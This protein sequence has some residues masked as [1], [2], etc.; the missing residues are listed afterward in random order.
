MKYSALKRPNIRA[1]ICIVF[2][3]GNLN[4]SRPAFASPPGK[5]LIQVA[6]VKDFVTGSSGPATDEISSACRDSLLSPVGDLSKGR[7]LS[8]KKTLRWMRRFAYD[9]GSKIKDLSWN[10]SKSQPAGSLLDRTVHS[11]SRL[12]HAAQVESEQAP[13]DPKIE[14]GIPS[15]KSSS[16]ETRSAQLAQKVFDAHPL[17]TSLSDEQFLRSFSSGLNKSS[18]SVEAIS[19]IKSDEGIAAALAMKTGIASLLANLSMQIESFYPNTTER[20]FALNALSRKFRKIPRDLFYK[21]TFLEMQ[22]QQL[23]WNLDPRVIFDLCSWI[24]GEDYQ[25]LKD[26]LK[27]SAEAVRVDI[28][29]VSMLGTFTERHY[30]I[31]GFVQP[32]GS[33]LMNHNNL[34]LGAGAFKTVQRRIKIELDSNGLPLLSEFVAFEPQI[35]RYWIDGFYSHEAYEHAKQNI[36]NEYQICEKI[37]HRLAAHSLRGSH[38][39]KASLV[40]VKDEYPLIIQDRFDSTLY[41]SHWLDNPQ[42]AL[43]C[44]LDVA[45]G[46]SEL[47]AIGFVHGDLK[48]ENVLIKYANHGLDSPK[49]VLSDFG[50]AYDPKTDPSTRGTPGYEAPENLTGY[51][52][53]PRED[54][55]FTSIAQKGDIYSFGVMALHSLN[56]HKSDSTYARCQHTLIRNPELYSQCVFKASEMLFNEVTNRAAMACYGRDSKFCKEA[57]I[58]ECLNP[59]PTK[60][61]TADELVSRLQGI[62]TRPSS[63]PSLP[64]ALDWVDYPQ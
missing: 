60:R 9:L 53:Q 54:L 1:F 38:I 29:S 39:A 37:A 63:Q 44:L 62:I 2:T 23:G 61:P 55:D 4:I 34:T 24:E 50:L 28:P 21:M 64:D 25:R 14:K 51:A 6:K 26:Q 19:R 36:A 22:N 31:S 11:S 41:D 7:G 5:I 57:I 3:L 46:L 8:L 43:L 40:R 56:P 20:R 33:L 35:T 18:Y 58:S 12:T 10:A 17:N 13:L 52:R 59:D 49:I 16:H 30:L 47:H 27:D 45:Q 48:E 42:K 15:K 32:D